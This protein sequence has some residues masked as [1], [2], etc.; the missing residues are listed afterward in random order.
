MLQPV[1]SFSVSHCFVVCYDFSFHP[2]KA[3]ATPNLPIRSGVVN[4]R[5]VAPHLIDAGFS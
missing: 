2:Q 3:L 4:W 1:V 5:A